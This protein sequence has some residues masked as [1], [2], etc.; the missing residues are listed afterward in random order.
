[1][2]ALDS[3]VSRVFGIPSL[4]PLQGEAMQAMLAGRDSLLVLPTG[5]GKSLTF[6][7]PA[8]LLEGTTIVVSP[9][10]SLMQDQVRGLLQHGVRAAFLATGQDAQERRDVL[11]RLHAGEIDLL[12][13]A[14]ERLAS[15]G[16]LDRLES[17]DLAALVVDEAHCISHWGHAFRP[18]YRMIGLIR[19]RWPEVSIHACTATATERVRADICAQLGLNDPLVLVGDFDRPN[20]TYRFLPRSDRKKQVLNILEERRG[21]AAIVYALR[22]ADVDQI[23]RDLMAARHRVLPYHAGLSD[24]DRKSNQEA[25]LDEACDVVVATVAF[26]MGIDRPDVRLVLHAA[27]PKSLEHYLQESG[28]AGRDGAPAECTLLYSG[29]DFHGWKGLMEREGDA[30]D[31]EPSLA[32]LGEMYG[33]ASS[34]RCRHRLLTEYFGQDDAEKGPCG[35][36]D[37]CLGE[38]PLLDDATMVARKILSCVYRVG[39]RFGA[40]HV[41]DVLRGSGKERVQQL[42]HTE[43]STFGLLQDMDQATLRG[44]ID[45]L[46]G[47]GLLA[48]E[49]GEYPVLRLTP[50]SGPVLRG[51]ADVTLLA[52][53]LPTARKRSGKLVQKSAVDDRLEDLSASD[54]AVFED[55]RTLRRDIARKGRLRPY[56]VFPDATLIAFA[57]ERPGDLSAL[58]EIKGVGEKKAEQFGEVFL[59]RLR[60]LE[61]DASA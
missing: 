28:R 20:L 57:E 4:R 59:A 48:I 47:R 27:M 7:A 17:I 44:A 33:A 14:P 30:V 2:E 58:L 24:S 26:G 23:T 5:G 10:I 34:G 37:V 25:F 11:R 1:M 18:E 15:E 40:G 6:Q 38:V 54:R 32:R 52:P 29:A 61:L 43:L 16:F 46:V 12:Y 3:L 56:Q 51:E 41:V 22:R 45:Q 53:V 21:R 55:L 31:L 39:Q 35:A 49:G 36:C 50:A 42:G 60:E 19:E 9:L 8:L 13:V